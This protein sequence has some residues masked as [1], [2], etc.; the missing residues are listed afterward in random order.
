M[1]R[2][3]HAHA[4]PHALSLSASRSLSLSNPVSLSSLAPH[5]THRKAFRPE[6]ATRLPLTGGGAADRGGEQEAAGDGG[7]AREARRGDWPL[8]R[9]HQEVPGPLVLPPSLSSRASLLASSSLSACSRRC[10]SPERAAA[11][12]CMRGGACSE[13]DKFR[14]KRAEEFRD[15]RHAVL[16]KFT[17]LLLMQ[18]RNARLAPRALARRVRAVRV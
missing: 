3:T 14:Q 17:E 16:E 4:L 13:L 9:G 18:V 8:H 7:G 11:A 15:K 12:G 10:P 1:Q 6:R 5:T 2:N